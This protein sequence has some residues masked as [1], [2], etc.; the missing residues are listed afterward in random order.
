MRTRSISPI[1]ASFMA[2]RVSGRL[3]VRVTMLSCRWYRTDPFVIRELLDGSEHP[4]CAPRFP[5]PPPSHSSITVDSINARWRLA[6][7]LTGLGDGFMVEPAADA[8]T[9]RVQ[10]WRAIGPGA[11]R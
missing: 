11:R 6:R 5:F 7:G 9:R 10:R 4:R 8:A 3:R 1:I 2:L